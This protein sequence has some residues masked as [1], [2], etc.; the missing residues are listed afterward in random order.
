MNAVSVKDITARKHDW[1]NHIFCR[2]FHTTMSI[3]AK[4]VTLSIALLLELFLPGIN[5]IQNVNF[6]FLF[7]ENNFVGPIDF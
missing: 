1:L 7:L 3:V 2:N 6:F 4:G 5:L